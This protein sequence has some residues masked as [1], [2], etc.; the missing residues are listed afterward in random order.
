[1]KTHRLQLPFLVAC[2]FCLGLLQHSTA[3]VYN[4]SGN[5]DTS[6]NGVIGQGSLRLS[7]SGSTINGTVN[8]GGS[9]PSAFSGYV[10]F[11]MDSRA[12]GFVDT[13]SFADNSTANTRT[14]SGYSDNG[15]RATAKFAPDFAADY[16]IVLSKSTSTMSIYPLAGGPT[17]PDPVKSARFNIS[18][19]TWQ[20]SFDLSDI[21][22]TDPYF[23]FQSTCTSSTGSGYRYLESYEPLTGTVGF[24]TVTFS[25]CNTFGVPPVPETT[26]AAL[27]VFGGLVVTAGAASGLRRRLA[28]KS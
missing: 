6:V 26:N 17:L 20:F 19:S 10:V 25:G 2:V 15:L 5:G 12:G 21:G 22:T 16:A 1:M 11:Y 28:R 23:K 24:N 9:S 14:V 3:A 27:A 18:G 4:Y 8:L 7:D 13:T